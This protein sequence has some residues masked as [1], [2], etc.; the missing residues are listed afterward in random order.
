MPLSPTGYLA[1]RA[2]E[3]LQIIR[4]E[5]ETSAGVSIDFGPSS[6]W[7]SVT[8]AVARRLGALS[9]AVQGISDARSLNNATGSQLDD[10]GELALTSRIQ[11]TRSTVVLTLTSGAS[12]AD[13]FVPTGTL[14]SGGGTFGKAR[15]ETL[16]DVT[17]PGAGG[18]ITA[19][20]RCTEDGPILA[21]IGTITKILNPVV[22]WAA[23]TNAAVAVA[24]TPTENNAQFRRRIRN[25]PFRQG[26][27]SPLS[28]QE[29]V[30]ALDAVL[31]TL[32]LENES[33]TVQ[34][35]QGVSLV[36]HS[37]AV[38]IWPNTLTTEEEEAVTVEIL[39]AKPAG[40]ASN[41]SEEFQI[42][43]SDGI[44]RTIRFQYAS[45]VA[46]IVACTVELD[47]G[48][49][50]ADVEESVELAVTEYVAGLRV[51]DDVLH[52]DIAGAVS[53]I[54][55]VR[56]LTSLINGSANDL[57]ILGSQI[58]AISAVTVTT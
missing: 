34:T 49:L 53:M 9:E 8:I 45:Q 50:L 51:G 6:F 21:G 23:V 13:T 40:I 41:G 44:D 39:T 48:F 19:S 37:F 25:A 52:L 1:L 42:T 7:G 31:S 58:A 26:S 20:A 35:I 22:G 38:I 4:D 5:I 10:I 33:G 15:W 54:S 2:A 18:T 30:Q 16:E 32:V 29:R 3:L 27:G 46:V 28:I 14:V 12:A 56:K 11:A 17:I 43:T 47:S 36:G 57:V 24:G 55:G